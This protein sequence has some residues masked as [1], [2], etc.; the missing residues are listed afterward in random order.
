[1]HSPQIVVELRE[2]P[3]EDGW[4]C[5]ESTGRACFICTCGA[6]TGFI[7]KTDALDAATGHPGA[8]RAGIDRE[9]LIDR[10]AWRTRSSE[11]LKVDIRLVGVG[12]E[13]KNFVRHFL[14][15]G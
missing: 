6:T 11:P 10:M 15:R 14:G 2:L 1:V 4:A 8:E 5:A 7:D 12:S 13:V 9:A 3:P